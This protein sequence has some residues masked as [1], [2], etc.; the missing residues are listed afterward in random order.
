MGN[1]KDCQGTQRLPNLLVCVSTYLHMFGN[2]SPKKVFA[3][4]SD[5]QYGTESGFVKPRVSL[6]SQNVLECTESVA[7]Y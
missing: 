7:A 2:I 1:L 6:F 3:L 5:F 4:I